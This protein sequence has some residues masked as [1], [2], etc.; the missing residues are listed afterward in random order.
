MTNIPFIE[1]VL[2]WVDFYTWQYYP[3]EVTDK[4]YIIAHERAKKGFPFFVA[5]LCVYFACEE[6]DAEQK[7]L[8]SKPRQNKSFNFDRLN[9]VCVVHRKD[10]NAFDGI[11][12]QRFMESVK[13]WKLQK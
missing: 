9:R 10:K 7:R 3:Q 13:T 5:A 12:K 6:Y 1:N 8:Q 11:M 2:R 4:A